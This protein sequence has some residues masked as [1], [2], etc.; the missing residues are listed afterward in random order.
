[1]G[2][3]RLGEAGKHIAGRVARALPGPRGVAMVPVRLNGALIGTIELGRAT[4]P[5]R[6]REIAA[7]E[8]AV[9]ALVQRI[10]AAR[11]L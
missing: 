9:D 1:M 5:F 11:W 2:E 6:A 10:E 3:M 7:V 4:R 8:Q